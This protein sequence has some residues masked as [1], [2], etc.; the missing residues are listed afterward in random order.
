MKLERLLIAAVIQNGRS[1][2]VGLMIA[3]PMCTFR[4]ANIALIHERTWNSRI[5]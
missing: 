5:T 2:V 1:L 3:L 4:L